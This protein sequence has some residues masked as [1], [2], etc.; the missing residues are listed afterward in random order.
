MYAWSVFNLPLEQSYGWTRNEIATT[1]SLAIFF[2]GL[3]A[4]LLGRTV[5]KYG[6]RIAG[7]IAS[8]LWGLGLL[9]SALATRIESLYLLWLSY[10]VLGGM[11]LG[12]GYITPVS[13]LV[14]WFPDRHGFAT[15]LAIMGF[16]FGAMFAAPVFRYI[17]EVFGIPS[18]FLI[19]GLTYAIIMALSAR[20]LEKPPEEW[21]SQR[22][23]TNKDL[24][25]PK[26]A[27]KWNPAASPIEITAREARRT[28]S[29][30]GLWIIMFINISCGIAVI[31]SAS[32]L[33]Q[34]SLGVS[35]GEAAAIVGFM[36]IFNGLG[37]LAWSSLSDYI[38]RP[39]TYL[40]F[41]AI[42]IAA[43]QLLPQLTNVLMFQLTL[44][45]ILTCY[46]GGFSTLPA[47]ISDLFGT[48]EMATI[49][50]YILTAWAAAGLVGPQVAALAREMTGSYAMT[51][52]LFSGAFVVALA[53]TISMKFHT[54][55]QARETLK[56]QYS[57]SRNA[58]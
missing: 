40:L 32:P 51:L 31:Y 6:P 4:A 55:R 54:S 39:T 2:L 13:T 14:K 45:T 58:P 49:H 22:S 11:G 15:G 26:K 28:V 18:T 34:E 47:Y 10:G 8:G 5:E 17:M 38:G 50:G 37:R 23:S 43:F 41:F 12:I 33:A 20:Y 27:Q 3:S 42:Q 25:S 53:T 48:K 35:A 16:G 29:F 52:T 24:T 1:F 21:S 30:Y 46:G 44:F 57:R 56:Y 7:F 9:G 19:A 36:S